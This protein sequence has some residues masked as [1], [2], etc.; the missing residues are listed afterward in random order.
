MSKLSFANSKINLVTSELSN[1]ST[2]TKIPYYWTYYTNNEKDF[3]LSERKKHV[4]GYD[5]CNML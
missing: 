4:A 1:K 5:S 3:R 2:E